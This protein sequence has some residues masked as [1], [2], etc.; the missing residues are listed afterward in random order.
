MKK[1]YI[2]GIGIFL[3]LVVII[4]ISI[5]PGGSSYANIDAAT[6]EMKIYKS[7]SCGCCGIYSNYFKGKGNSDV[8]VVNLGSL[9][10]IKEKYGIPSA[11]ESCH[12]TVIGGYFVEGHV[13]L[14]A[15]EKLLQE[16]PDI[17]GIAM[18]G[19]PEGSPGMPGPKR[20]DFVVYAVNHDK[21]YEEFMRI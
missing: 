10:T 16:K 14:E 2:F 6:G 8:E 3:V 21:S 5:S 20:G 15:V 9:D 18:P 19:M 4:V 1:K 11:M 17:A 7:V 13:P 12:T